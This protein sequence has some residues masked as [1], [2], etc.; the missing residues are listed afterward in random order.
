MIESIRRIVSVP[1]VPA[2]WLLSAGVLVTFFILL[3]QDQVHPAVVY[4]LEL[5]LTL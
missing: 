5:Y 2:E 3:L 1:E 4:A